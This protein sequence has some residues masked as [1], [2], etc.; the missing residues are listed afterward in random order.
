MDDR[1]ERL[2]MTE[3]P[4]PRGPGRAGTARG[5]VSGA[6]TAADQQERKQNDREFTEDRELTEEERLEMFRSQMHQSVLPDL[7][8]MLGFH[9]IWL[10]TTNG[11]DSIQNRIRMGYQLLRLEDCPGWDGV[12]V[13]AGDYSGVVTVNEMVAAK[14]PLRLYNLY[15]REAHH[16]APLRDEEKLIAAVD[17]LKEQAER[18]GSNIGVGDGMS[19]LSRRAD[20]MPEFTR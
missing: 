3:G 17:A 10:T 7:P 1:D 4:Q 18:R 19:E 2:G 16:D 8:Y 13:K 11:R 6:R 5:S 14:L 9:T 15:M 20:R 12:S